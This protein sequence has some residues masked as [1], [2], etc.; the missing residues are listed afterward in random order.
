M[1]RDQRLTLVAAV[2]G[3][4]AV[5]LDTSVV[6][7]ALPAIGRSLPSSFLAVL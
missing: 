7:V 2:V 5:F 1:S 4:S 3:S 6:S